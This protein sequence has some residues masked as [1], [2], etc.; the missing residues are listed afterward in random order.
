[1]LNIFYSWRFYTFGREQYAECMNKLFSNNLINLYRTN[2]IIAIVIACLSFFPFIFEQGEL[3]YKFIKAGIYLGAA[4]IA[5]LI[6]VLSNYQ[7]QQINVKNKVIYLLITLYYINVMSLGAFLDIWSNST[8]V[9]AIFP[10][11]LICSL[12]IFVNPPRFNLFLTTGAMVIFSTSAII[13]IPVNQ[14]G[15]YILNSFIAGLMSLYFSWQITKLRMGLEIST[16]MLE[17]EKNKYLDQSTVDELTQLKNRRDFMH[18]F[19]R[20][21]SNYRSS[22]DWLCIALADID[23]FKFYNDHYGHPQGD[24]CLRSIGDVLNKLRDDMGVYSAR[25]GGEEFAVLWFE[26]DVTHV[27]EVINTWTN[28]IKEKQILHEK[29]KVSDYVTMSIGVYI[30]RCGSSHDTQA[31]Y[32]FA[33]KALY[34]A[35]GGGR[36]CTVITGD[37]IKQYKIMSGD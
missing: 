27:D 13:N 11:F 4:L 8:S 7:M 19:Q 17:E 6:A 10:C 9:A 28:M 30:T 16:T 2:K 1:M 18:T 25:V 26:R 5:L 20:Y 29:S 37:E 36:N 33:D 35:K 31:L 21:L 23:F 34:A 32:D 15:Y 12:L 22:D 3:K 24:V 14:L